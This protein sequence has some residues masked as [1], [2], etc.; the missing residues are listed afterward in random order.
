MPNCTAHGIELMLPV[1]CMKDGTAANPQAR[2]CYHACVSVRLARLLFLTMRS[3][4]LDCIPSQRN[5][6]ELS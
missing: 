3:V 6:S 4:V 1:A 5:L 2:P